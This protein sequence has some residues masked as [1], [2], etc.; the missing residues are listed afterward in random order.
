MATPTREEFLA[1][2][3]G[4]QW[5]PDSEGTLFN[6][7]ERGWWMQPNAGEG[8]DPRQKY[9]TFTSLYDTLYPAND[10]SDKPAWGSVGAPNLNTT[11]ENTIRES[12]Q[13]PEAVTVGGKQYYRMGAD[14]LGGFKK[15]VTYD[16][17]YGYLMPIEDAMEYKQYMDKQNPAS[18]LT[19]M[20]PFAVGGL[21]AA[22]MAPVAAAGAAAGDTIGG[23]TGTVGTGASTGVGAG[24]KTAGDVAAGLGGLP[25]TGAGVGA[26]TGA[27][28]LGDAFAGV[29]GG[30][31]GVATPG[32]TIGGA[33]LDPAAL[34]GA[35]GG[36]AAGFTPSLT[37]LLPKTPTPTG[38]TEG[39]AIPSPG[40]GTPTGTGNLLTPGNVISG[41]GT[42]AGLANTLGGDEPGGTGGAG[43]PGI[44]P[45]NPAP[46][47]T[48]GG[49]DVGNSDLADLAKK[50]GLTVA[51]LLSAGGG[52]LLGALIS[53]NA[54]GNAA[55][56]QKA[57][58]QIAAA[59]QS[60]SLDKIIAL[61]Q[62]WIDAGKTALG[63]LTEGVK[64]GGAFN[65]PYTLA[66]FER[67][68]Q[69]KLFDFAKSEANAALGNRANAGGAANNS[70]T[71]LAQG[72]LAANL[73]D[74]YY[75]SGFNQ[76]NVEVNR[77]LNA[78]Q[79]L[80]GQGQTATNQTSNATGN[81]GNSL[82]NLT[83]GAGNAQAAGTVGQSNAW[84]TGLTSLGN[85]LSTPNAMQTLANLF[86]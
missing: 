10:P 73:A 66:D 17:Q 18:T 5:T 23:T 22:I 78:N 14:N 3:G 27:A 70:G 67:Q 51:Q 25:A 58:A 24:V 2:R 6:N 33:V 8:E 1:S 64:P 9:N 80:A 12:S 65:K 21:A 4:L 61:Q 32:A 19:D 85:M 15:N 81:T 20:L 69:N 30:A 60:Q 50:Y 53:A 13:S 84:G 38:G 62:P 39:G 16:P 31:G 42:G 71:T 79:S 36:G 37:D 54:A 59:Q 45:N 82:A 7:G 26:S 46:Q 72:K 11:Y 55:D 83:L 86:A 52:N 34:A 48:G 63:T 56:A 77:V 29:T 76:N 35:T 41:V 75:N 44:D 47:G 57:A 40:T 28:T 43:D 74:Q 68:G 49:G